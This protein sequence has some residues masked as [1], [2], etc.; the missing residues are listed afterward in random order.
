MDIEALAQVIFRRLVVDKD[1]HIKPFSS[2]V[3][4]F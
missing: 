4:T 2:G 1:G 3:I